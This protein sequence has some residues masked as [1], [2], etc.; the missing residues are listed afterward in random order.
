MVVG[1]DVLV[2][3]RPVNVDLDDFRLAGKALGVQRHTV[4]KPA[5]H[6]NEQ[7]A[8]GASNVGCLGAVHAD[9]A[10]GQRIAPR[11]AAAAHNGD[12]NGR[13][14]FLCEFLKL[15]VGTTS[16]HAAAADEQGLFRLCNHLRQLVHILVIGLRRADIPADAAGQCLEPSVLDVLLS[17]HGL[18][19]NEL[20]GRG[21]VF[22][23][24]NEHRTGTSGGCHCKCFAHDVGNGLG[25][26]HQIGRLGD[27]HCNTGNIYL[28]ER[29]LAQKILRDIAGDK[30]HGRGIIIGSGN[31]RGQVGGAGTGGGKAHANLAGGTGIAVGSMGCALL[32]GG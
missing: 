25:V 20:V 9:H 6:R 32:M 8:V 22:Q 12:G 26:P 30:H 27:G 11:E 28:L 7:I 19:I 21:D 23:K 2:N 10:G 18:I 17:L 5:A 14:N 15:L 1:F 24:V 3:F 29:I 4:R 13:I 31:T 16:Y